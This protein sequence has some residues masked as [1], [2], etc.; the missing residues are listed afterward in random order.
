MDLVASNHSE[1]I[2]VVGVSRLHVLRTANIR[3]LYRAPFSF[4]PEWKESLGS[5]QMMWQCE[6]RKCTVNLAKEIVSSVLGWDLK[7]PSISWQETLKDK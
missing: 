1:S 3:L 4:L 5:L 2:T 7:D 6:M